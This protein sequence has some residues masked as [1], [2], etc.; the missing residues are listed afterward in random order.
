MNKR[1]LRKQKKDFEEVNTKKQGEASKHLHLISAKYDHKHTH[2]VSPISADEVEKLH[3]ID[4]TLVPRFFEMIENGLE[5]E[6]EE[7][8]RFYE[9]VQRE[10]ENDRIA[11]T[12]KYNNDK[13]AMNYAFI[14][15]FFL[16]IAGSAFI[17]MGFEFIGGA[18]VTTVLLGVAKA[19]LQK[20]QEKE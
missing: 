7:S 2:S 12:S 13:N 20:K 19:M 9:S 6:K 16:M 8:R 11:I 15:I 3:N 5:S 1:S 17:Y 18:V 14:T 4:P 10:Q